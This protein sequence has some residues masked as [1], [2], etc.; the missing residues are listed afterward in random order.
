[1]KR[2]LALLACG[3]VVGYLIALLRFGGE[4]APAPP[5]PRIAEPST[6]PFPPPPTEVLSL[7]GATQPWR[8]SDAVVRVELEKSG[9]GLLVTSGVVVG[10]ERLLLLPLQTLAEARAAWFNDFQQR[11]QPLLNVVA[12]DYAQGI[13]ALD[14]GLLSGPAMA[15]SNDSASLYLGREFTAISIDGQSSGWVDS[16]VID[17]PPRRSVYEVN[18]R[19]PLQWSGGALYDSAAQQLLGI[20]LLAD[21]DDL[22]YEAIDAEAISAVVEHSGEVE[23]QSLAEFINHY[24]S[25][26]PEGRLQQIERFA[27][28][29]RWQQALN[30]AE[31]LLISDP[32]YLQRSTPLLS[33][34]YLQLIKQALATDGL[35]EA[36]RLLD[37]AG[38]KL[39]ASAQRLML[40]AELAQ[41]EGQLSRARDYLH[42]ALALETD[43]ALAGGIRAAIRRAV[44]SAASAR[45]D[46]IASLVQLLQE[47]IDDDPNYAPYHRLLGQ[48]LFEQSEYEA[49]LV[50]LGD[51]ILLDS[52]LEGELSSLIDSAQQKLDTPGLTEVPI[53]TTDNIIRL[54]IALNGYGAPFRFILDT[55]ASY[56]VITRATADALGISVPSGA[57]T[58]TLNTA[59]G[60]TRAA[61]VTLDSIDLNGAVVYNSEVAILDS[62]GRF[63]GL[64]GLTFL[65]N[66]NVEI[67]HERQK[68]VLVRR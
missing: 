34:I 26:V 64:L 7:A 21:E 49:A 1:M 14:S 46:S 40:S 62:L 44:T 50:A 4:L 35:R 52:A 51:A 16:S 9:G 57:S 53:A 28:Q 42:Q 58:V 27:Q 30:M 29:K 8:D 15:L 33:K 6:L 61:L 25:T 65:R 18:I 37:A 20:A 2:G 66:F 41:R 36:Q 12:V 59:N 13:V 38:E 43:P 3:V 32:V 63:D 54:S 47:E 67:D 68:L 56:S 45:R 22:H 24:L 31:A 11:R 17:K 39:P 23:P 19:A 55:G 48:L 10:D 60:R 5:L